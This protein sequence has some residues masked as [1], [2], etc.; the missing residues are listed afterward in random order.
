MKILRIFFIFLFL[1]S[2]GVF[3]YSF[4]VKG[5]LPLQ[6]DIL[7]QLYSEPLQT[8][9]HIAPFSRETDGVKYE[10]TPVYDYELYGLV[11][12]DF[13][14]QTKGSIS[15]LKTTDVCVVWGD[16][17]RKNIYQVTESQSYMYVCTSRS[18]EKLSSEDYKI[19]AYNFSNNHLYPADDKINATMKSVKIGDQIMVKGYLI[20]GEFSSSQGNYGFNTSTTRT[21]VYDGTQ[22]GTCESIYVTDFQILKRY[23]LAKD[24]FRRIALFTGIGSILA[25]LILSIFRMFRPEQ[26][27]Y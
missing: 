20:N 27:M 6:K 12:S 15:P 26:R 23:Y 19:M 1:L 3:G 9:T 17:I 7:P 5:F 25:F 11:M 4:L 2:A 14:Y 18:D 22:E 21:D 16:G 10:I 8:E 24:N 13:K